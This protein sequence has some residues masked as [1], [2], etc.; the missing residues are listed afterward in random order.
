MLL[1]V[2]TMKKDGSMFTAD[3][4]FPDPADVPVPEETEGTE[5]QRVIAMFQA[6]AMQ[7]QMQRIG[8]E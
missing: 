5:G 6:M 8:R 3:D 7:E 2:W 1:S 4:V